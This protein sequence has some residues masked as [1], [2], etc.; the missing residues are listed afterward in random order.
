MNS[1]VKVVISGTDVEYAKISKL[2]VKNRQALDVFFLD[3]L[4]HKCSIS[5]AEIIGDALHDYLIAQR[6]AIRFCRSP[7]KADG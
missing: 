3:T 4:G 2:L 7:E 6:K 5:D 1:C